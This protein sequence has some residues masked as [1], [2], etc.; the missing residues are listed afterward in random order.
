M[1]MN[2]IFAG[3]LANGFL[4]GFQAMGQELARQGVMQREAVRDARDE[5]RL[6]LEAEFRRAEEA[7][8]TRES[9]SQIAYRDLQ[10]QE[11]SAKLPYAGQEAQSALDQRRA[12]TEAQQLQNQT[13]RQTMGAEVELA[14][15]KP[16]ALRAD[17]AGRQAAAE[18]QQIQNQYLPQREQATLAQTQAST[19]LNQANLT[20]KQ[21]DNTQAQAQQERQQRKLVL[22][23]ASARL[24]NGEDP[25]Q[26]MTPE[27]V[28]AWSR[29]SGIPTEALFN[30]NLNQAVGTLQGFVQGKVKKDTP[31]MTQALNLVYGGRIRRN[32]D[33]PVALLADA[34]G[35]MKPVPVGTPGA[36]GGTITGKRIKGAF[37]VPQEEIARMMQGYLQQGMSPKAAEQAARNRIAVLLDV[38]VKGADGKTYTYTAPLTRDGS[39][40][41][42]DPVYFPGPEDLAGPAAAAEAINHAYHAHPELFKTGFDL[43]EKNA[44]APDTDGKA[45]E[46]EIKVRQENRANRGEQRDVQKG[47]R[48]Q[49]DAAYQE[50]ERLIDKQYGSMDALGMVSFQGDAGQKAADE[51]LAVGRVLD[52]SP[53]LSGAAALEKARQRLAKQQGSTGTRGPTTPGQRDYRALWR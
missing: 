25:G 38:D 5:R 18:S 29:Q 21:L 53:G 48:Q 14:G 32:L 22:D 19:A 44:T 28:D 33:E 26:V 52:R 43:A 3:G 39:A 46:Q 8:A 11:I 45:L 49:R 40:R 20:G 17:I 41:P 9:D 47:R 13:T 12:T 35:Q 42:D 15:L 27:V 37:D 36:V 24:R 7:R 23:Q 6:Q 51:K 2:G 34:N 10:G 31:A 1:A 16:A 4:Q 30:G 50:A